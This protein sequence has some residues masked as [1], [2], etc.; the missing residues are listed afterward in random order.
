M[1]EVES[2]TRKMVEA[3]RVGNTRELAIELEEYRAL[4]EPVS[5]AGYRSQQTMDAADRKAA[6]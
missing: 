4:S 1:H 2:E 5:L 3:W 6:G